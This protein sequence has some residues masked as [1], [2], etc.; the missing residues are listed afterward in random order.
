[1]KHNQQRK[2]TLSITSR[3]GEN[4]G[5]RCRTMAPNNAQNWFQINI[6]TYKALHGLAPLYISEILKSKPTA[7]RSL[8]SDDENL[9]VALKLEQ[10]HMVTDRLCIVVRR[11]G[12]SYLTILKTVSFF[13][14]SNQC[15]RLISLKWLFLLL[16]DCDPFS[17]KMDID[18][19]IDT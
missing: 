12:L 3:L 4:L 19:N 1:M 6:L 10:K 15:W 11:C 14:N 18:V 8:R 9:L 5:F 16:S 2:K 17:T 7:D 13:I